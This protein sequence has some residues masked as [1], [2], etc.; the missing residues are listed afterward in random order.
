MAE[1]VRR[2]DYFHVTVEDKPGEAQR[3]LEFCS[4]HAVSLLNITTFPLE[5]GKAQ[6]DFFPV[7][8]EKLQRAAE[9]AGFELIGPKKAFVI[10]G[11]DRLGVLTEH[12][13]RLANA[14][15]NVY[16]SNGTITGLGGFGYVLWVKDEDYEKA[17]QALGV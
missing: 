12:H 3:L 16:A 10:Q 17:A 2:A 13:L 9:E 1:S 14:G 7:N 4:A 8:T 11:E 5:D 15:V 6:I